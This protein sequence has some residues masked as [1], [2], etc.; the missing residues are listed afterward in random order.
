[1]S[2][3]PH[4]IIQPTSALMS[5]PGWIREL[6][7]TLPYSAFELGI[8]D[9]LK[10]AP[11][12]LHLLGRAF[13]KVFQY[14]C[15][16]QGTPPSLCVFFAMNQVQ[17]KYKERAQS[18]VF[19]RQKVKYFENY[20]DSLKSWKHKYM[21]LRPMRRRAHECIFWVPEGH[22]EE[23]SDFDRILKLP[24]PR[25]TSSSLGGKETVAGVTPY[26]P[27]FIY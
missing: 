11:S 2:W 26:D 23:R 25:T 1:M 21:L 10:V 17:H 19:F 14:C 15:E 7:V 8:L 13:V 20:V 18:L 24:S 27:D 5:S 9:H 22:K 3:K 16:Y 12:Q 6:H 4:H